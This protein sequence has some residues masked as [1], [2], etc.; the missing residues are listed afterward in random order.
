[1][2]F[3][4]SL[5]RSLR[6]PRF[7]M[8]WPRIRIGWRPPGV[9]SLSVGAASFGRAVLDFKPPKW[10]NGSVAPVAGHAPRLTDYFNPI[11]WFAWGGLFVWR[12]LLTRPYLSLGAALPAVIVGGG[13]A[14]VAVNLS[15]RPV[16]W[17]TNIYRNHLRTAIAADDVDTARLAFTTLASLSPR[18]MDLQFQRLLF[19][20]SQG[21]L[22]LAR[23]QARRLVVSSQHGPAALWLAKDFLTDSNRE[24]FSEDKLAQVRGLLELAVSKSEGT[25]RDEA[26]Q[27]LVRFM[28]ATGAAGDA[29]RLSDELASADQRYALQAA[30]RSYQAGDIER[31]RRL[32]A[33]AEDYFRQMLA[34]QPFNFDAR[35]NLVRALQLSGSF[36]EREGIGIFQDGHRLTGDDRFLVGQ[37][38]LAVLRYNRLSK[39]SSEDEEQTLI[40]RFQLLD[41]ALSAAPDNP[42]VLGAVSELLL[43]QQS[44]SSQELESVRFKLLGQVGEELASFVAATKAMQEGN[45]AE[46]LRLF[47]QIAARN[48]GL[49]SVLNNMAVVIA[50][51]P[52]GD[53]EQALVLSEQ[54]ISRL[55]NHP[56][57]RDTRGQILIKLGRYDEALND[58]EAALA[59]PELHAE[60]LPA[61]AEAY[62]GLG[63]TDLAE[64]YQQRAHAAKA[65]AEEAK[66]KPSQG[67]ARAK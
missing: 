39:E 20:A 57:L 55:P 26:R 47:N 32:S 58:L 27:M 49:P 61:M 50:N 30:L 34:D 48:P 62:R 52:G 56:Y 10:F 45:D 65:A 18:Q 12:W 21:Q 17:R 28:D 5:R 15:R 13:L 67:A 7:R 53:L 19:E 23:E 8:R 54:A 2:S 59:A 33:E 63:N 11:L 9:R 6:M 41:L 22:E 4:R 38:E 3:I 16:N 64:V 35:V 1:V 29:H 51:S 36:D 66:E 24:R 60:T 25:A 43:S 37:A 14:L 42:L 44:V 31:S 40:E 46:A